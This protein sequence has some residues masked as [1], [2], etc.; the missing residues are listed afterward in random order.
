[1]F[2]IRKVR[3][4]DGERS[5][6]LWDGDLLLRMTLRYKDGLWWATA[7]STENIYLNF[8]THGYKTYRHAKSAMNYIYEC[9]INYPISS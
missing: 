9:L 8:T 6:E 1:M 4:E 5:I 7:C 3:Y 2:D